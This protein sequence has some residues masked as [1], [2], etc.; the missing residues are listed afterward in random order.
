M[1]LTPNVPDRPISPSRV[2]RHG[3]HLSAPAS[4]RKTISF[5]RKRRTRCFLSSDLAAD[6]TIESLVEVFMY[7][8]LTGRGRRWSHCA[9]LKLFFFSST[10]LRWTTVRPCSVTPT[11]RCRLI[12]FSGDFSGIASAVERRPVGTIAGVKWF[13]PVESFPRADD[14]P[15]Q[16][17]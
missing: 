15:G 10:S 7:T 4:E 3:Q 12:M 13:H 16:G 2:N 14:R 11:W 5:T 17:T 1:N 9:E 8:M 6:V